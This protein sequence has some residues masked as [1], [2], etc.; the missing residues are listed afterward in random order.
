MCPDSWP[1]VL[2]GCA[3]QTGSRHSPARRP[4]RQKKA[5][6]PSMQGGFTLSMST[7]LYSVLPTCDILPQARLPR[8]HLRYSGGGCLPKGG[9]VRRVGPRHRGGGMSADQ[10]SPKVLTPKKSETAPA[11]L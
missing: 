8:P 5:D 9:G 6:T 3:P 4:V 11:E 7:C 10:G 1:V 2:P